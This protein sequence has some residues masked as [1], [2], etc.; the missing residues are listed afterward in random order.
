ML[1]TEQLRSTNVE[2]QAETSNVYHV[3]VNLESPPQ[4]DAESKTPNIRERLRRWEEANSAGAIKDVMAD[5]PKP[6]QMQNT[7]MRGGLEGYLVEPQQLDSGEDNGTQ[8][9]FE[10]GELVDLGNN[11]PFLL[12]GDL[13]EL[14]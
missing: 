4:Y 9:S 10:Q 5:L 11:R 14:K 8:L 6:G 12:R 2:G 1:N 7:A 3:P 13:V